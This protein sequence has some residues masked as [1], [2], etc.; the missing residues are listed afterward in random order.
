T[1]VIEEYIAV[2]DDVIADFHVVAEREL[3]VVKRLEVLS[4][5]LEDVPSE[6]PPELDTEPHVLCSRGRAVEGIPEPE[7]GLDALE[8]LLITVGVVLGLERDV[9]R[10]HGRQRE[11]RRHGRPRI[12]DGRLPVLGVLRIPELRED[13]AAHTIAVRGGIVEHGAELRQPIARGR[14][15]WSIGER[16]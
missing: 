2:D 12:V 11:P 6:Y 1:A 5:S 4:T 9:A 10:V 3:D 15:D 14:G 8:A 13:L 7:Q 16:A